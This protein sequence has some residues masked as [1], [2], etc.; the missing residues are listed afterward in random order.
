MVLSRV[1]GMTVVVNDVTDVP[2]VAV[3][4]VD[5]VDERDVTVVLAVG[6]FVVAV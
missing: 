6:L 4:D 3:A 2:V 5:V 1:R